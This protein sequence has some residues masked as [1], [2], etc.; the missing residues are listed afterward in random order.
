MK[1]RVVNETGH[2]FHGEIALLLAIL[3]MIAILLF[4]FLRRNRKIHQGARYLPLENDDPASPRPR[5]P[6]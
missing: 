5:T 1:G 3:T 2:A 6:Q 4:T